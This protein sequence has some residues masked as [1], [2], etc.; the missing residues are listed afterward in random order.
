MEDNTIISELTNTVHN[1]VTPKLLEFL[2]NRGVHR[3]VFE[4]AY[5]PILEER[6]RQGTPLL[7]KIIGRQA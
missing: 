6:S 1:S 5:R 7:A 4:S 3:N 2:A